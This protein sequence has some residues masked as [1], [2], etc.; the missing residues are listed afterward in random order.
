[1]ALTLIAAAAVA[2]GTYLY[3]KAKRASTGQSVAAG[4]ATGAATAVT[5]VVV[6]ALWPVLLLGGV[7]GGAYY[8][9]KKKSLKA[10]PPS[11][12]P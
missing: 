11:S 4:A 9:G 10:L 6:S 5:L 12:N 2:G 3:A 7:A 1:M 8:L